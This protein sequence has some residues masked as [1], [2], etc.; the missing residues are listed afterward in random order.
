MVYLLPFFSIYLHVPLNI[1][2]RVL[3]TLFSAEIWPI[4]TCFSFSRIEFEIGDDSMI[5]F[6]EFYGICHRRGE[7]TL[8]FTNCSENQVIEKKLF[9]PCAY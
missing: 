8:H 6:R 7:G 1:Y 3:I 4:L 5:Q 9:E 2:K